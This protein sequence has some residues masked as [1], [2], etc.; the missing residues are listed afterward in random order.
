MTT[1]GDETSQHL[2]SSASFFFSCCLLHHGPG[3]Y[4]AR[5]AS[6]RD[7]AAK[8]KAVLFC[9]ATSRGVRVRK[10]IVTQGTTGPVLTSTE[11]AGVCPLRNVDCIY[12]CLARERERL[13][14]R[15]QRVWFRPRLHDS[16]WEDARQGGQQHG[17]D[18]GFVFLESGKWQSSWEAFQLSG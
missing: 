16:C 8:H 6:R 2:T 7:K 13:K 11:R 15:K 9:R 4:I 1:T 10:E 17:S 14:K 3:F 12:Q 18:A 5:P